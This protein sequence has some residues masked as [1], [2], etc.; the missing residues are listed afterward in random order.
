MELPIVYYKLY[1]IDINFS[2]N[3]CFQ[4]ILLRKPHIFCISQ[5]IDFEFSPSVTSFKNPQ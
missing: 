5:L 2:L 1:Y 4:D 3:I